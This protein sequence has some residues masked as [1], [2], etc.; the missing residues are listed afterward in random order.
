MQLV[1]KNQFT[2]MPLGKGLKDLMAQPPGK[3]T[4]LI[5][6]VPVVEESKMSKIRGAIWQYYEA[7]DNKEHGKVASDKC[8]REI[9]NILDMQWQQGI[10][11]NT[12]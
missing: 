1:A 2:L 9:Q 6:N 12:F 3:I 8:L 11:L 4:V 5:D 10:T 7:L